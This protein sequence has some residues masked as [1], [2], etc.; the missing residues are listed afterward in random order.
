MGFSPAQKSPLKRIPKKSET[1]TCFVI[2]A[3]TIATNAG[4]NAQKVPTLFCLLLKGVFIRSKN[5]FFRLRTI[6]SILESAVS[7]CASE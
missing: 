2:K 1:Q 4:K 7:I 3:S 6:S 5:Y